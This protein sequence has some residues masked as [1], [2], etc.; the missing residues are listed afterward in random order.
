MP[1]IAKPSRSQVV[2]NRYVLFLVRQAQKKILRR[3]LMQ[4]EMRRKRSASIF[5]TRN[6]NAWLKAQLKSTTYLHKSQAAE[7]LGLAR[8]GLKGVR[9]SLSNKL[10]CN[11]VRGCGVERRE[12]SVCVNLRVR[13][14]V[15]Y[16]YAYKNVCTC[17]HSYAV[18]SFISNMQISVHT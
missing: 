6:I 15:A 17:M 10:S 1:E 3:R 16:A 5:S 13:G 12:M 9:F 14:R 4:R 2:C 7:L 8:T 18:F 11:P